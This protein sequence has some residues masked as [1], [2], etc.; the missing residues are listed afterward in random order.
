MAVNEK[1]VINRAFRKLIDQSS[2]KWIKISFWT[3]ACDVEFDDGETA[4]NKFVY[5]INQISDL[6]LQISNLIQSFQDG[7]NKIFEKLKGLGFT[8]KNNSPDAICDAIDNVYN[9]RY[10]QGKVEGINDVI[11]NP[12]NYGVGG[13]IITFIVTKDDFGDFEQGSHST[14]IS[15]GDISFSVTYTLN[16]NYF[17]GGLTFSGNVGVGHNNIQ[18]GLMEG[19]STMCDIH[20]SDTSKDS[21][22]DVKGCVENVSYDFNSG[23]LNFQLLSAMG[24]LYIGGDNSFIFP[25]VITYK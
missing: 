24:D 21:Y 22:F 2:N 3:K 11:N 25:V 17:N 4:E 9:D 15:Y 12:S 7:V 8:P 10:N 1:I 6:K 23:I 14:T 16:Y 20:S 13:N 5:F 19:S 18:I